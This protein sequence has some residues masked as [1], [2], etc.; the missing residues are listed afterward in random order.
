MR[1]G[2]YAIAAAQYAATQWVVGGISFVSSLT[3]DGCGKVGETRLGRLQT[4]DH[5]HF[6]AR[7]VAALHQVF[8]S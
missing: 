3:R 4:S 2:I 1:S 8:I 5:K 7:H 6:T